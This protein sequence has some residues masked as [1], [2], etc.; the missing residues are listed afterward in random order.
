[1]NKTQRILIHFNGCGYYY[2]T[3]TRATSE[4]TIF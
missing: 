2:T 3:E 4:Q 1:M